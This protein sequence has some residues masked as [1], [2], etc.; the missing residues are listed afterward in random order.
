MQYFNNEDTEMENKQ[1]K[2]YSTS[3]VTREL[4]TK[5]V[6]Y[7]YKPSKMGK[8]ENI[9]NTNYQQLPVR[10]WNHFKYHHCW[11][12]YK[13]LQSLWKTMWQFSYKYYLHIILPIQ[14]SNWAPWYLLKEAENMSP[15]THISVYRRFIQTKIVSYQ[16]DLQYVNKK[17][18]VHVNRH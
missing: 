8:I 13:M 18:A 16:N 11:R 6:R 10:M 17:T 1:R 2:T 5:T 3:N 4:K 12:E 15:E 14:S 7:H 9:D